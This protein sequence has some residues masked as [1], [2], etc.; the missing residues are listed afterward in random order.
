MRK[1]G[2]LI[3]LN[4]LVVG[5]RT[6][7]KYRP[8]FI[9][10]LSSITKPVAIISTNYL[11]IAPGINAWAK[12]RLPNGQKKCPKQ[13]ALFEAIKGVN[14]LSLNEDTEPPTFSI[15]FFEGDFF[16]YSWF[17][18]YAIITQKLLTFLAYAHLSISLSIRWFTIL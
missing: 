6:V 3:N 12:T 4:V 16:W 5:G 8:P 15:N 14:L 18:I 17:S 2:L 9:A 1:K 11:G 7:L 13:V 10:G